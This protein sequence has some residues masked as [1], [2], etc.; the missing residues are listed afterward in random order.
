MPVNS[1]YS[2]PP[3]PCGISIFNR[4]L[5][6]AL[7]SF[8][9]S[10]FEMNLR[11]TWG[12]VRAQT[13]VIHYVPSA[14]A[15]PEAS[16]ALM[17]L[18]ASRQDHQRIFVIL[19]GLHRHGE[20]RF[21]NDTIC[22]DQERHIQLMFNAAEAIIALSASAVGSCR[23]WQTR[24]RGRARLLRLDHPG[25]F[26]PTENIEI[27]G[28]YALVGGISRSKKDHKAAEIAALVN[29]CENRGIRVW[30]HW[31][32]VS[33]SH[34]IT[35]GWRRTSGTLTDN[36][37]S[38]L[39]SRALVVLCPYQTRIQS[40]S[41]LIS[42]ALSAHRFVLATSFELA[43]EMQRRIPAW[44]AIED[45]LDRWPYLIQQ[46]PSSRGDV[47]TGV[48]TWEAF[49]KCLALELMPNGAPSANPAKTITTFG[50]SCSDDWPQD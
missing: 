13:S 17:Q 8:G 12:V 47:D 39:V 11:K 37:W 48:P 23:S 32:N 22:P 9:I 46:L 31:T 15:D 36:E 2:S 33:Q 7:L 40:V 10:L 1:F 4:H 18:L 27:R 43:L 20:D 45:D 44:V 41:G 21:Q 3:G 25:L 38:E 30:Q 49:A 34:S 26:A 16:R 5:R 42:E 28:S 50:H 24:L 6:Q 29:L 14:F 35:P 19:H